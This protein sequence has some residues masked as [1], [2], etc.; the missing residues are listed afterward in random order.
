M[1]LEMCSQDLNTAANFASR[2]F[3]TTLGVGPGAELLALVVTQQSPLRLSCSCLYSPSP[4]KAKMWPLGPV[5]SWHLCLPTAQWWRPR[6][7]CQDLLWGWTVSTVCKRKSVCLL[8]CVP[9]LPS[10]AAL[11]VSNFWQGWKS[12]VGIKIPTVSLGK[13]SGCLW[14][15]F[16]FFVRFS[17]SLL[18]VVPC[19]SSPGLDFSLGKDFNYKYSNLV[20]AQDFTSHLFWTGS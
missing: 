2:V 19:N 16:M 9:S 18:M 10:E 5:S 14:G 7:V 13:G 15:L 1:R 11:D 3:P 17:W 20:E 6:Q 8:G 4:Q 12:G